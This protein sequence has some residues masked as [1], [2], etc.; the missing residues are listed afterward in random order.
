MNK[1]ENGHWVGPDP[2]LENEGQWGGWPEFFQ[3]V[4]HGAPF[5]TPRKN[6]AFLFAVNRISAFPYLSLLFLF[7]VP[8]NQPCRVPTLGLMAGRS[9]TAAARNPQPAEAILKTGI[10]TTRRRMYE[11]PS[12]NGLFLV[13]VIW[14]I[15]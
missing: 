1:I 12:S 8:V 4:V 10:I 13:R 9:A 11:S 15:T 14:V 2:Q 6:F 5:C 3:V 7:L